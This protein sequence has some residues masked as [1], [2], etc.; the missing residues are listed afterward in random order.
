MRQT[1]DRGFE[2]SIR[3]KYTLATGIQVH[4]WGLKS[5]WQQESNKDSNP[6]LRHYFPNGTNVSTHLQ[7]ELNA[8]DRRLNQ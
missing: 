5:P 4:C 2:F 7:I 6:P 8:V 1:Q 3:K